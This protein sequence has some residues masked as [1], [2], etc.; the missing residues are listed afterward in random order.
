MELGLGLWDQDLGIYW[1]GVGGGFGEIVVGFRLL[2][3]E[4][5]FMQEFPRGI[6]VWVI[7]PL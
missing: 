2:G 1:A 3:L 4:M 7:V 6:S 5:F